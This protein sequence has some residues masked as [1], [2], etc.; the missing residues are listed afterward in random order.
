MPIGQAV[1]VGCL[2]FFASPA[3][4]AIQNK[5]ASP[6]I[7]LFHS[8][9]DS[10]SVKAEGTEISKVDEGR[11]VPATSAPSKSDE[12]A[13]AARS[14]A[15]A[16]KTPIQESVGTQVG[17]ILESAV[18]G[19]VTVIAPLSE[20]IFF[21]GLLF[22]RLVPA[23]GCLSATLANSALF[24]YCHQGAGG[25]AYLPLQEAISGLF[26]SLLYFRTGRLLVPFAL[27][28]GTNSLAM[29]ASAFETAPITASARWLLSKSDD[30]QAV[31]VPD[32]SFW[33]R[34]TAQIFG[35]R[36]CINGLLWLA[37][38]VSDAATS[39]G[40]PFLPL[41]FWGPKERASP[42]GIFFDCQNGT[43]LKAPALTNADGSTTAFAEIL[44]EDI[45]AG[46]FGEEDSISVDRCIEYTV[47]ETKLELAFH[48]L[49]TMPDQAETRPKLMD[50]FN[51]CNSLEGKQQE[52]FSTVLQRSIGFNLLASPSGTISR[53]EFKEG[54][55]LRLRLGFHSDVN[56]ELF[57]YY[58]LQKLFARKENPSIPELLAEYCDLPLVISR[59]IAEGKASV[60]AE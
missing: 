50:C 56:Q 51:Y 42:Q 59:R 47:I 41:D 27:H 34:R 9:Y 52:Q 39:E 33:E 19:S 7:E 16:T 32:L 20:E 48:I 37:S 18:P 26:C 24:A 54:F 22:A 14:S 5:V 43:L 49:A 46:F 28:S 40:G 58:C 1:L 38:W 8:S 29:L 2:A 17:P 10:S 30:G 15:S 36:R 35:S 4:C 12:T 23:V 21:R 45:L 44:I 3:V 55:T 6:V 60:E 25:S 31:S 13:A 11:T 53:S 57:I